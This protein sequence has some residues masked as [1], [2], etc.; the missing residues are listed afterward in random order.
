MSDT[1]GNQLVALDPSTGQFSTV[2]IPT[3]SSFPYTL[4]PGPNDTLWFPELFGA[5]IG[6]LSSNGTLRE[7]PLPGGVDA[8]PVQIVFANSTTGYYSDVGASEAGGG[9]IY[10]FNASHF[11]PVLVGGQRLFDPSSLTLASGALWVALHGSSSVAELQL[12]DQELVLLPHVLRDLGP[13]PGDHPSILRGRERLRGLG[14]RALRE[15]D[16]ADRPGERLARRVF[17]VRARP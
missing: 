1:S 2:K 17:R 5:K 13:E 14:Q 6:E 12:H 7:Y 3:T 15:Q 4:T 16:G 11:S 10:S 8:E 9:G